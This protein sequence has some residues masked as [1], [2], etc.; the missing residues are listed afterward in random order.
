[1]ATK[2]EKVI[3]DPKKKREVCTIEYHFS[4][5]E[6]DAK[7]RELATACQDKQA[8]EDKKKMIN[9]QLKAEADGISTKINLLSNHLSH[10]FEMKEVECDVILNFE[11]GVRE[12]YFNGKFYHEKPLTASDHQLELELTEE[13]S[14]RDNL[15]A[16][17]KGDIKLEVGEYYLLTSGVILQLTESNPEGITLENIERRA[18]RKEFKEQNS[19]K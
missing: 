5:E 7:A 9:S 4:S 12:I 3:L 6:R 16:E 10:G 19:A 8:V 1:M 2:K 11:K 17:K 18:T 14:K 15:I 13:M